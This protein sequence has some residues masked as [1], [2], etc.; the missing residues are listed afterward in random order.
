MCA[1][2]AWHL[3]TNGAQELAPFRLLEC[4]NII[5]GRAGSRLTLAISTQ[6][7]GVFFCNWDMAQTFPAFFILSSWTL[8]EGNE[9]LS[10]INNCTHLLRHM[11]LRTIK[12]N[13]HTLSTTTKPQ[14]LVCWSTIDTITPVTVCRT[15]TQPH[16][17]EVIHRE[18]WRIVSGCIRRKGRE[19]IR[20]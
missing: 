7:F 4:L 12:P 16:M 6:A 5:R 1:G 2:Q 10:V 9:Q 20:Q 18:A 14:Q 15:Q 13:V 19:K 17:A 8:G 11:H 3:N